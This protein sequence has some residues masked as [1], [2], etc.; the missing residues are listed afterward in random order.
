M[1]YA[2]KST[3]GF[4]LP[5]FHGMDMPA[6]VVEITDEYH[7][8]LI[9][10]QAQGRIIDWS[11]G[12]P[13]LSDPPA[14]SID[15]LYAAAL[16]RINAG[17][18]RAMVLLR[19]NYPDSEVMSWSQQTKEADALDANPSATTPL[20]AAIATARGLSVADL[21]ARVRAKTAAYA[22]ASGQ[23]IGQRQALEDAVVAVDLTAPDAKVQLEVIQWPA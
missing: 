23:I 19:A 13:V 17:C 15:D 9:E 6:D 1:K 12:M 14:P 10:G 11:G 4:Y 5:D 21:A 20:L 22:L 16:I 18:E 2:S 8:E 3:R 7:A